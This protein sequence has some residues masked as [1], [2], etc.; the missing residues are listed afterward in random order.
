MSEER[1]RQRV[2]IVLKNDDAE[3]FDKLKNKLTKEFGFEL[4]NIAVLKWLMKKAS[5][6]YE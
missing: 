4:N 2:D 3:G 1:I 6:G 5:E